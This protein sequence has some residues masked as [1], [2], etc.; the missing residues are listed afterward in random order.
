MNQLTI[1]YQFREKCLETI[2]NLNDI[3]RK[4]DDYENKF[5]CAFEQSET[6]SSSYSGKEFHIERNS[7]PS[8]PKSLHSNLRHGHFH[9]D[10]G[11]VFVKC[12]Y[13]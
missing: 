1:S 7:I 9:R 13:C 8:K 4:P 10:S 2:K 5:E 12:F 6:D 11:Y 3:L